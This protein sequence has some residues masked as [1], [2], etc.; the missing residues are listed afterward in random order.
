MSLYVNGRT[1]HGGVIY[2][3]EVEN[4]SAIGDIVHD[5]RGWEI[6]FGANEESRGIEFKVRNRFYDLSQIQALIYNGHETH[7]EFF[8]HSDAKLTALVIDDHF[9][10]SLTGEKHISSNIMFRDP[11]CT[12]PTLVNF[13]R[14]IYWHLRKAEP[15]QRHVIAMAEALV[16]ELLDAHTH[17][18]TVTPKNHSDPLQTK[19]LLKDIVVE[20]HKNIDRADYSLDDLSQSLGTTKFHLIRTAKR[21]WGMTPYNYLRSL[22]L[23]QARSNLKSTT[24]PIA[25]IATQ[26]GFE[27]LST[28]NKAFKKRY[29]QSPTALRK[30]K[31]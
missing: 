20:L 29:G 16:F 3:F 23:E 30:S 28:F 7:H 19:F 15:D 14:S 18:Q 17:D 11:L 10:T 2:S 13:A 12:K 9:I 1:E 25:K 21:A 27:D 8:H 22:R 6:V 5:H 4:R 24:A 31:F 26:C